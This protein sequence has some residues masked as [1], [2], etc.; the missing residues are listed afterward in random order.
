MYLFDIIRPLLASHVTVLLGSYYWQHVDDRTKRAHYFF[1]AD[2][3]IQGVSC[4][5]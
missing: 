5:K 2:Q 4:Y 1:P 3:V